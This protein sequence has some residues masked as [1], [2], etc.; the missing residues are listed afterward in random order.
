MALVPCKKKENKNSLKQTM[1]NFAQIN[2]KTA[3]FYN[4]QNLAY[5]SGILAKK[6]SSEGMN[7]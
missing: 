4:M 3:V 5:N 6:V 7:K 2:T 1:T